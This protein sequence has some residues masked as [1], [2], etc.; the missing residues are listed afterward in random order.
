MDVYIIQHRR[1]EPIC[2]IWRTGNMMTS[3]NI[4]QHKGQWR[5]ALMISL[6]CVWIN[7]WVNNR[8]AGDL[9]RYRPPLWRHSNEIAPFACVIS[10]ININF[11]LYEQWWPS[12]RPLNWYDVRVAFGKQMHSHCILIVL[13]K[14]CL[15]TS[16]CLFFALFNT[17]DPR[18]KTHAR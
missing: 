14:H 3:S 5:G 12:S 8:E 4:S 1:C 7:G 6:I 10:D 2:M 13:L 17:I 15:D 16:F 18:S 11:P 9:R